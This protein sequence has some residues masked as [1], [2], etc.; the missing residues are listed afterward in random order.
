MEAASD[1]IFSIRAVYFVVKHSSET[2]WSPAH[3]PPPHFPS[4]AVSAYL[5]RLIE[6]WSLQASD[7]EAAFSGLNSFL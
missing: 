3:H 7:T 4:M 6:T 5:E 2:F 1:L